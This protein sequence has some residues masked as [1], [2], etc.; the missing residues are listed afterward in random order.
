MLES[1]YILRPG[2]LFVKD[3]SIAFDDGYEI[4]NIPIKQITDLYLL[5][6]ILPTANILKL[7]MDEGII[8]HYFNLYDYYLGSLIPKN[9]KFSGKLLV[10]EVEYYQ[11][12]EKRIFIAREMILAGFK[13]LNNILKYY[14]RRDKIHYN[15]DFN[16][17]INR[18]N[19]AKN[20]NSIMLIEAEFRK[21]YYTYFGKI[22]NRLDFK[23]EM[24]GANDLPNVLIN[25]LNS[26]L[27]SLV[28][29]EIMKTNLSGQIGFVHELA[30]DRYPLIY[31]LADLFKP[32]MVDRLIFRLINRN[33]ISDNDLIEG[34]LNQKAIKTIFREWDQQINTTI[35]H[36]QLKR[37]VSYRYL[38]RRELYKIENHIS[39]DTKYKGF[40]YWW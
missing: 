10:K 11:D 35:Y 29:S 26:L 37:N 27:Y 13:N 39:K 1:F 23:R 36:K 19:E 30:H 28:F 22:I 16:L 40:V 20:I 3:G 25:F 21:K 4:H 15:V 31:D 32:I 5:I 33:Q 38:I 17:F 24:Q 34:R 14:N 2:R 12:E 8:I 9:H 7:I 18:V 6:D